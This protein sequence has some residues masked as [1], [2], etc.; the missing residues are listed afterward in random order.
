[1]K[2]LFYVLYGMW[3]CA[4]SKENTSVDMQTDILAITAMSEARADAFNEGD[5]TVIAKHFTEDGIL[6]APGFPVS[7]GR[8]AIEAYYADIFAAYETVLESYYEEVEV[9]GDL[10]FGRGEAKV[11]L[12]DRLTADTTYSSSKYL[13][14]LE[15][16]ADG[17]WQTTHDIWND[18]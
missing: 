10:A 18:N 13:N 12:V 17:S 11:I 5:A 14:I 6:M 3:L 4:C 8:Q 9:S 2:Y 7:Q 16:Q 1:M 15:K